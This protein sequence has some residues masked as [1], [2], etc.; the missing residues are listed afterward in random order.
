MWPKCVSNS[1]F[2]SFATEAPE[3]ADIVSLGKPLDLEVDD[4]NINE[5]VDEDKE[6]MTAEELLL[7]QEHQYTNAI[8]TRHKE[9]EI[10]ENVS[11]VLPATNIKEMLA[12]WQKVLNYV[13]KYHPQKLSACH[14]AA[15]FNDN[16]VD[17]FRGILK[18]RIGQI[19]F[20]KF[21]KKPS[22]SAQSDGSEAKNAKVSNNDRNIKT[23]KIFLTDVSMERDSHDRQ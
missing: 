8:K 9:P 15:L 4:D 21:F 20:D 16:S 22:A 17:Y 5:L 19:T 23:P 1:D 7:L 12:M 18:S 3:V 13:E 2:S 10:E 11:E 14:A 6:E